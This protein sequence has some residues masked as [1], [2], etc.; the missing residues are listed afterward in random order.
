MINTLT[1]QSRLILLACMPIIL[2]ICATIFTLKEVKIIVHDLDELYDLRVIP[3]QE[4]KV[5][6]D[7][8]AVIIV[9]TFHKLRGGTVS[10]EQA[11]ADILKAQE[12]ARKNW[13]LYLKNVTSAEEKR[14]ISSA[15]QQREKVDQLIALYLSAI[16]ESTFNSKDYSSF[17]KE[18]YNTFDPLSA[19]FG[20]LINYQVKQAQLLKIEGDEE[21]EKVEFSLIFLSVVIVVAMSSVGFLIYKSIN[22]PLSK[23]GQTIE[24]VVRDTDL[25]LRVEENGNDEFS[26]IAID[27][28]MMMDKFNAMLSKISS[29]IDSLSGLSS[30]VA[31]S[32]SQIAS[33]AQEQEQQT[34]MIAQAITEMSSAIAEVSDSAS[35]TATNAEDAEN[36]SIEGQKT[37]EESIRAIHELAELVVNNAQLINEL[38]NQTTEINQ[39]V[40]MIQGVAE[41]TNLLALNAAIEA[42]RA[43]DS[44]RGFAVVADEVRT[45]AHNT[46]KA[47]ENI[48]EMISKLQTQANNAVS[49]MSDAENR[50]SKS[51]EMAEYSSQKIQ[52]ISSSVSEIASMNIQASTA[53]EEQ[54]CVTSEMSNSIEGFNLSINEISMSAQNNSVSGEELSNM[55]EQLKQEI[56]Q[57]KV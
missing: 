5:V 22:A 21:A 33:S 45:L 47:T 54:T 57:F 27:F 25:T 55:A 52:A 30:Q 1:V 2:F 11:I 38:N 44:G 37:I 40:M 39:V 49:A 20:D 24:Q 53:T 7:D 19:S 26:K 13:Q 48:K 17:V 35:R 36:L 12:V 18:V 6:S 15:E 34:A 4:I 41:Q 51:V 3:M 56:K 50:A 43:G 28:N 10:K 31:R 29:A 32:G 46:Q 16:R 9:D 42:A 23:M 14:L 8:Y